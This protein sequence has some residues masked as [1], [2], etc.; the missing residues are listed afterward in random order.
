[1]ATRWGICGAGKIS[2]D[3]SV[4]MKTLPP[5]DHQVL[6]PNTYTYIFIVTRDV[7]LALNRAAD[8]ESL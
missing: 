7:L 3:F 6:Y 8:R 5:E 4:A 1:M 2:H